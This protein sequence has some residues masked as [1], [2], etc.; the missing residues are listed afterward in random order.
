MAS[1]IEFQIKARKSTFSAKL[2]IEELCEVANRNDYLHT[3]GEREVGG[4]ISCQVVYSFV[5]PFIINL[6]KQI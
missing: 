5:I 1:P 4:G 6:V 2:L 3:L